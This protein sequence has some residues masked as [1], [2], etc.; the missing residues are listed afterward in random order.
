MVVLFVIA[1][2]D[3]LFCTRQLFAGCE[4]TNTGR[5]ALMNKTGARSGAALF[6]FAHLYG[7]MPGG[8]AEF[9]RVPHANT[10]PS[11]VPD[12]LSDE[13]VMFLSDILTTGY[14]AVVNAE[15]G[16]GR[17]VAILGAGPVGL[18]AA[19]CARMLGAERIFMV[20]HHDNR[21]TF[22]KQTYGVE[23]IH[24]D[25]VDDPAQYIVECT[26]SRD[27]DASIDAVGFEAKCSTV[28]TLLTTL[29]LEGSSGHALR[30]CIATTRRGGIVSHQMKL[31]DA[32]RGYEIFDKKDKRCRKVVLTPGGPTAAAALQ[33]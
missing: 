17:T 19:A 25:S 7:G 14:L 33:T 10:G 13:Q 4:T 23:P 32:A 27:V 15:V 16:A 31:D 1:R 24:F 30:Q 29:K 18:M 3:C 21:L 11:K 2:G 6:G 22:A 8:Q 20:D 26:A 9:L 12:A 5:S 28:E